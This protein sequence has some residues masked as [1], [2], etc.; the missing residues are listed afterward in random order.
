MIER[1]HEKIIIFE[2]DARFA[3]NFKSNL[4]YFVNTMVNKG[5]EWELL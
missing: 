2:D 3:L 5:V 4:A 1:N